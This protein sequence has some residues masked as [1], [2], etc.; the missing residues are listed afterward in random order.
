MKTISKFTLFVTLFVLLSA[1]GARQSQQAADSGYE[2]TMEAMS[3]AVGE[4]NLMVTLTDADG[5]PVNDATLSVKGDMSHA[6]MQPV[7]S[8]ASNGDNGTYTIPFEWTM[9]GDWI[10]T[11][12]AT[13][14][15]GTTVSEQFDG[16]TIS[17]EMGDMDMESMDH[18]EMDMEEDSMTDADHEEMEMSGELMIHDSW[19]RIS[20]PN[21]NGAFYMVLINGTDEE[22]ALLSVSTDVCGTAELHEMV[23]NGEGVMEM[24]PVAGGKI[25]IPAH[26]TAELKP[27]GMHVMCLEK[28]VAFELDEEIMLNLTFEQ[29]G[30][31][32]VTAVIRESAPMQ[33]D[34]DMDM[35]DN[36]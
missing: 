35:E 5:N 27:G 26:G 36:N 25:V 11:I 33:M 29:A 13:L 12:D 22:D 30:E 10:V 3:T 23:D 16:I 1:C 9:G 32:M 8:E 31:K 7:L 15:D 24:N 19:G 20:P 14:P 28:T 18:S 17:G 2:M 4:T 21:T 6:G 34:H